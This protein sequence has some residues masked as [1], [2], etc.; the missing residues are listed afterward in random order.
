[1]RFRGWGR[2]GPAPL[3]PPLY[4]PPPGAT[5][6]GPVFACRPMSFDLALCE[7][8]FPRIKELDDTDLAQAITKRHQEITP[9]PVEQTAVLGLISKIKAAIEKI[10]AAPDLLPSVTVEEFR[11]VGSFR[12]G[13]MLAGHNVADI[14]VVL[15]SLPTVEAVSALGQKIV[16]ELKAN[17]KEVYGCISRDFGCELAGPNAIVRLLIT[18][19]PSNAKLLEPDLHLK[20]SI[21]ISHM[22]ALR[23]ARWFEENASNPTIKILIRIMK[24]IRNRFDQ[25]KD[26]S[27]W[28][29]E[30][31][32]HY[33]V[34]NTASQ[35]PLSAS[36]AFRRFFQLLAAGLL[37][38]TSPALSDPCEQAR[39]IH[40]SLTYE[41]MVGI[42]VIL[43]QLC[44]S[45][46]TL[47]R[48][49]CH[50]GY[51]HVL[52][53][54]TSKSGLVT[55]MT[56]WGDVVVTP[57]EAAY[58]DKV[59]EPM[60]ED[61]I[62]GVMAQRRMS[63]LAGPSELMIPKALDVNTIT[64]TLNQMFPALQLV[65]AD[66]Q[67]P[68]AE[69][70]C[71]IYQY[72]TQYIM[73]IPDAVY[74]TP[75]F[76]ISSSTD[77]DL[78]AQ[79]YPKLVIFQALSAIVEDI[80]SNEIQ[81]SFLDL[82]APEPGPTRILLSTL[83]NFIEFM[84][85][86]I[87][88]AHSIFSSVD[89]RKSKLESKKLHAINLGNEVQ[90]L[91]NKTTNRK[92]LENEFREKMEILQRSIKETY[93]QIKAIQMELKTVCDDNIEKRKKL[94]EMQNESRHLTFQNE[95]VDR[96]IVNSPDRLNAELSE[97]TNHKKWEYK[98]KKKARIM[99]ARS[100][101]HV[102]EILNKSRERQKEGVKLEEAIV[103][104]EEKRNE[105]K[106]EC[107]NMEE[108]LTKEENKLSAME[109]EREK[110]ES[111]HE[112]SLK[113]MKE[114]LATLDEQVKYIRQRMQNFD[115]ENVEVQREIGKTKNEIAALNRTTNADIINLAT[116]L[117]EIH[118]K[119]LEGEKLYEEDYNRMDNLRNHLIAV[120]N[121]SDVDTTFDTSLLNNVLMNE[122]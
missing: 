43:D 38:P 103:G 76:A 11:E 52:G 31:I 77:M 53:L 47:L 102:T 15:R 37:L 61:E 33:A 35:Q 122:M 96:D 36:Q 16:E 64:E 24:D 99:I 60:Y 40:Q 117:N 32:S 48:I 116:R 74:T 101:E 42:D 57:L 84:T 78:F 4:G 107:T 88:K 110:E 113:D 105:V 20:E 119:Y 59:M 22:A 85:S 118:N 82:V 112:K 79:A 91:H 26:L 75:L 56:F 46:Q 97:L 25:L 111:L 30:L 7:A 17:D 18:T 69:V 51:K 21:M 14:V 55:D 73:D 121:A 10:S 93:A 50:G 120:L 45:S 94:V 34:V 68:T 106:E 115:K 44:S 95:V 89:G 28:N 65:P 114:H 54:E 41:Q 13:T 29:I 100:I 92:H 104:A 98:E 72:I 71:T 8:S 6:S 58:V 70:M 23:H 87:A 19:V 108:K 27:V 67:R 109:K 83:I 12:K 62:S 9:T 3:F 63:S 5:P 49:I 66:I 86:A 2:R 39:R 81:F 1:M 90:R 80:S